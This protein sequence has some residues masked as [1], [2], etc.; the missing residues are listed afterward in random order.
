MNIPDQV[1]HDDLKKLLE[2]EVPDLDEDQA[3]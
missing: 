1:S 3:L 2:V